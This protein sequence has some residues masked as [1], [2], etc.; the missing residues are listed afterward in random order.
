M[1]L[2]S[3]TFIDGLNASNPIHATDP[4]SQGDDHVRLIK[5]TLL[6]TFPNISAAVSVTATEVNL[7]D[8]ATGVTG[9]GDL[10][11]NTA[12]TFSGLVTAGSFAGDLDAD[13]L[14]SGTV[15]DARF[16]ATLPAL[17]GS[18]LTDLDA[19]NLAAGTVPDARFPAT[20]PA[21]DGSALTALNA[22][23]IASGTLAAA[24][25][26]ATFTQAH[27][28]SG[29]RTLAAARFET[30]VISPTQLAGGSSTDNYAPTG[31]ST[32]NV[33]R[34]SSAGAASLTGIA[35][36][37][38]GRVV[39]IFNVGSN[40]ITLLDEN[41]GSTAANRIRTPGA[42]RSIAENGAV[43]IWYDSTSSRWRVLTHE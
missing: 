16:P 26:P 15:P 43:T 23:N 9:T 1:G 35:G 14:A 19:D 36:G 5:S 17:N 27:T 31:F 7:L 8:G 29:S 11:L 40:S 42:G 13:D 20:L 33:M 12:P 21:A 39:R 24:R 32:C 25:L 4:V 2:E 22:D 38:A 3:A 28:F 41:A 30:A 10:V 34:L 18:A 37:A 6:N